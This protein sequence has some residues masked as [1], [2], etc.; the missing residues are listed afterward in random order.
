MVDA[1]RGLG[2]TGLLAGSV[3]GQRVRVRAPS[4]DNGQ[5]EGVAARERES[6]LRGCCFWV[7]EEPRDRETEGEEASGRRRKKLRKK[8]AAPEGKKK[9][10][11][12]PGE[13]GS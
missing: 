7:R 1:D 10:K 11:S 2:C 13:R 5:R 4:A 8:G 12:S 6:N 9:K 3:C